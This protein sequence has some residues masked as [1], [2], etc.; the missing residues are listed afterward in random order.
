MASVKRDN[1]YLYSR[2]SGRIEVRQGN[3]R[4]NTRYKA[5]FIFDRCG[6]D[7]YLQCT[8]EPGVVYS[9]VVWLT[10]RDD[11]KA[12]E[13]FVEHEQ[14]AIKELQDKI[15]RHEWNIKRLMEEPIIAK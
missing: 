1:V 12:L 5:R 10:E 2:R 11:K 7:A 15:E 3:I 8:L 6:R 14:I 13:L 9:G 4:P